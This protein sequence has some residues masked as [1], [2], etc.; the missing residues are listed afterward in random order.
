MMA[1]EPTESHD[2]RWGTQGHMMAGEPTESHD[3]R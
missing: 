1:G 2:G 3:G